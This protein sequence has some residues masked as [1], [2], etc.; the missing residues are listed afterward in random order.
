MIDNNKIYF[1][2]VHTQTRTVVR[3]LLS[4]SDAKRYING[5]PDLQIERVTL[6]KYSTH[7][8]SYLAEFIDR[9]NPVSIIEKFNQKRLEKIYIG[10]PRKLEKKETIFNDTKLGRRV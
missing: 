7:F 4:A 1:T 6:K 9:P 8:H 2:I 10:F 5:Y 3:V